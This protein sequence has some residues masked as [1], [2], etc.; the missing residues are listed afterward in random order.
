[1]NEEFVKELISLG[2][3]EHFARE[4]AKLYPEGSRL[5]IRRIKKENIPEMEDIVIICDGKRAGGFDRYKY[6][7]EKGTQV[8]DMGHFERMFVEKNGWVNNYVIEE[9][10]EHVFSVSKYSAKKEDDEKWPPKYQGS[11]IQKCTIITEAVE[12]RKINSQNG[13]ESEYKYLEASH[14]AGYSESDAIKPEL[15]TN[16]TISDLEYANGNKIKKTIIRRVVDSKEKAEA[17]FSPEDEIIWVLT[18][19]DKSKESIKTYITNGS[20][21]PGKTLPTHEDILKLMQQPAKTM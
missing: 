1:M 18:Q 7:A 4:V 5:E 10:G 2:V 12:T 15:L 19:E 9:E 13:Q 17:G 3:K 16:S 11:H 20:L 14:N 21:E 8:I 6:S